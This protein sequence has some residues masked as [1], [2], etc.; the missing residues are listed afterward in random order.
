MTNAALTLELFM[1]VSTKPLRIICLQ[2][3]APV[4]IAIFVADLVLGI[5]N[6]I[7]PMINVFEMGFNIKG[8]VGVLLVHH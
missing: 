5:T 4:L 3:S 2:L 8:F 7:A 1:E 6:R